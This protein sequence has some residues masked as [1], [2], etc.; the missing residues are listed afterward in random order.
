[1]KRSVKILSLIFL[2][3][4]TSYAFRVLFPV[5][6][7]VLNFSYIITE[8][9]EQKDN[10]ENMCLGKCHLA[11][12]IKKQIDAEN[13]ESKMVSLEF[14]KIPHFYF[15]DIKVP[16]NI[17][18]AYKYCFKINSNLTSPSIEPFTPPPKFG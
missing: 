13:T 9:C 15:T 11:K 3:S 1:M 2:F 14:I 18:N 6:D 17:I 5:I 7:Y 16:K 10:P 4:Y 8:L 12:E